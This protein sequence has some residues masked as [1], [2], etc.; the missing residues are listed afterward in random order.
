MD[1][2]VPKFSR[3]VCEFLLFCTYSELDPVSKLLL[4]DVKSAQVISQP[5]FYVDS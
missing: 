1:R 2:E 3:L 5:I 4:Q